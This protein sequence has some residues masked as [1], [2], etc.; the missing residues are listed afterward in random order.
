VKIEILGSARQDLLDGCHFYEKQEEGIGAYFRD[1]L[2]PDIDSLIVSAGVHPIHFGVY[3]RMLSKRFP[4][5]VYYRVEHRTA[6]VQAARAR[7]RGR[8]RQRR[9]Q[10]PSQSILRDV[11]IRVDPADLDRAFQRWNAVHAPADEGLA[12]DG[13]TLRNA[14]DEEGRQTHVLSAVGHQTGTCYTQKKWVTCR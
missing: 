9:Y 7:F 11:L 12:I 8:Y 4:F 10:V 6:R 2:I 13:K 3:H 1:T 14:I 5:A